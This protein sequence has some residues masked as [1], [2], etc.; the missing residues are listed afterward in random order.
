MGIENRVREEVEAVHDTH[1]ELV[2][3]YFLPTEEEG[4]PHD[5]V[6]RLE[7][8]V[9]ALYAGIRALAHELERLQQ[10]VGGDQ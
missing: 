8:Q 9:L 2:G 7:G 6:S 10:R 1:Q 5:R 4:D 3:G